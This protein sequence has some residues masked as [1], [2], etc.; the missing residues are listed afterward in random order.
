VSLLVVALF[1]FDSIDLMMDTV[2]FRTDRQD[3]TVV[4]AREQSPQVL[5]AVAHLPGV[6]R[7]EATRQVPVRLSHGPRSKRLAISGRTDDAD[8]GRVLDT[9]S[10]TM[11]LPETG[12]AIS[13]RVAELLDLRRGDQV[14]VEFMQGHHRRVRV[15]VTEIVQSYFGLVALMDLPALNRLAGDGPRVNAVRVAVDSGRLDALYRSV[16]RTP[17][18]GALALQ[19]LVRQKFSDTIKENIVIMT[20]IYVALSVI[21]A[22]GIVFNIARIQFSVHAHEL[23]TLR[24]LGFTH[25]EVARVLAVE[26]VVLLLLAQP[27]GWLLGYAFAWVM[28]QAYSSDLYSIPLIVQPRSFAWASIVVVGAALFS[29]VL[30]GRRVME[31]DMIRVLKAPE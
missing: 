13:E 11:R 27:L 18:I 31:L 7:S 6:L 28:T 12:L 2:F 16:K 15:P 19:G 30:V 23:A 3:A 10:Q 17:E 21:V 8:L 4:L 25:A 9:Q 29:A 24:V 1:S 26:I 5:Q 14:D 20:T 22:F